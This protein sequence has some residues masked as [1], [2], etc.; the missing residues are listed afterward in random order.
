MHR[1]ETKPAA[2]CLASGTTCSVVRINIQDVKKEVHWS[3]DIWQRR[4]W[5]DSEVLHGR[6]EDK[7]GPCILISMVSRDQIVSSTHQVRFETQP[8]VHITP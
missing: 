3:S 1:K 5:K 4:R 7:V 6:A 8:S 2:P